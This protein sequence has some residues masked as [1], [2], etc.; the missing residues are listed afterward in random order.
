MLLLVLACLGVPPPQANSVAD[1]LSLARTRCTGMGS[2]N[3]IVSPFFH[4]RAIDAY[5][6]AIAGFTGEPF[7]AIDAMPPAPGD[8][9]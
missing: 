8:A 4:V 5:P 6:P 2:V 3:S 1:A 7:T 9:E